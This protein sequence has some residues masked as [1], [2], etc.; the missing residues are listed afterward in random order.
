[1]QRYKI[2]RIRII[3][4]RIIYSFLREILSDYRDL[5][6]SQKVQSSENK[7]KCIWTMSSRE[8]LR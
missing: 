6:I 4:L 3:Q 1:M 2:I 8:E 7:A 5:Q